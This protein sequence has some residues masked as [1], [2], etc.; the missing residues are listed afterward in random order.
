MNMPLDP[1]IDLRALDR[2]DEKAQ[3]HARRILAGYGNDR[4][5]FAKFYGLKLDRVAPLLNIPTVA[6][7]SE[8]VQNCSDKFDHECALHYVDGRWGYYRQCEI[9]ES[10]VPESLHHFCNLYLK[11]TQDYYLA[12]DGSQGWLGK[13]GL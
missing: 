6:E 9:D 7:L 8:V 13:R 5:A 11:A 10:K 3:A 12:R 2:G 1:A 4:H